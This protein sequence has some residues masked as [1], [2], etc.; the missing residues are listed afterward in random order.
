MAIDNTYSVSGMTCGHCAMSVSEEVAQIPGVSA[1]AVDFASGAL[2]FAS[3]EPVSREQVAA[4]VEE[5]GY[6]LT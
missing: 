2:T 3:E 4:A 1:I 5:A 6:A